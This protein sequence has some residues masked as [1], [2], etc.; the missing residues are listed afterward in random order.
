MK[1][2]MEHLYVFRKSKKVDITLKDYSKVVVLICE[3]Q[4]KVN[5][6]QMPQGVEHIMTT[7]KHICFYS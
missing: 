2:K 4:D 6:P 5:I 7:P 1:N 3:K